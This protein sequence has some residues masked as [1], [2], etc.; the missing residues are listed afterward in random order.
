[1]H[2]S[3]PHTGI[4]LL[5]ILLLID[6]LS[7][8]HWAARFILGPI[9]FIRFTSRIRLDTLRLILPLQKLDA[10]IIIFLQLLEC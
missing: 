2:N 8:V 5:V 1:M 9:S 10:S 6:I 7:R 3:T 4:Y